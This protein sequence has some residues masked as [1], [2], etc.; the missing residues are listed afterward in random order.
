MELC[1]SW[2]LVEMFVFGGAQAPLLIAAVVIV[3]SFFLKRTI[4]NSSDLLVGVTKAQDIDHMLSLTGL[5]IDGLHGVLT[6]AREILYYYRSSYCHCVQ[7]GTILMTHP[8]NVSRNAETKNGVLRV[9][10]GD[11]GGSIAG[12]I[13]QSK[14]PEW[15][16]AVVG[17]W[18]S[19][20]Q[21]IYN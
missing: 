19:V 18:V 12:W 7:F 13:A 6:Y 3:Q 4:T 9:R 1:W 16:T 8:L 20:P 11:N 21:R 10:R 2:K 15:E 14:G 17:M 5:I